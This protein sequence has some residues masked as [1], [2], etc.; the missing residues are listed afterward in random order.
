MKNQCTCPPKLNMIRIKELTKTSFFIDSFED[1][2]QL[3][4]MVPNSYISL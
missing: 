1:L 4:G 3:N 2:I